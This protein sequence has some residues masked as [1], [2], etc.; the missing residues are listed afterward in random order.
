M[1]KT[2]SL[3]SKQILLTALILFIC[4]A[5]SVFA[6][7]S[8]MNSYLLDDS[9]AIPLIS[10]SALSAS[11]KNRLSEAARSIGGVVSESI[12]PK[13]PD[14]EAGDG[15]KLWT[16][17]TQ[18]EI[19]RVSYINGEQKVTVK[20]ENGDKLIAPG[21]ES[22]YTFKLKNNGNTALDYT[23]CVD[24]CFSSEDITVPIVGR[25]SRYDGQWICGG[26]N[27]YADVKALDSAQDSE[28]L[29]AGRYTYYTLDWRWQFESGNDEYDTLLGNM[30]AD[31][32][33]LFTIRLVTAAA[34]NPDPYSGGGLLSPKT[35][36]DR[37]IALCLSLVIVLIIIMILLIILSKRREKGESCNTVDKGAEKP[38]KKFKPKTVLRLI[39]LALCTAILGMNVYLLNASVLVGN[40]LPMPFGYGAAVVLSGS[41]EPALHKDDMIIVRKADSLAEGDIAVF[42]DG[43]SLVVHRIVKIDGETVTTKGDANNISDEPVNIADV[44]GRAV[45]R[46]PFVGKVI[47]IIKTPLGTVV[48]IILAIALVEIPLAR[49]KRRDREERQKILDE[50]EQLKKEHKA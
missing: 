44:R 1:Q 42:Q 32:D 49:E 5:A 10:E 25:I 17:D 33:L 24:A 35:G 19:F 48:I 6:A 37:H 30:A 27:S 21:T 40:R 43:G 26:K 9:G 45:L 8:R 22:S 46:I 7:A 38:R 34:E 28:T 31:E 3:K 13:T 50:I 4:T 36:D 29:A 14:L 18:V 12:L 16:T 41:M 15:K 11:S 2:N 39:L 47:N 20:G 23:V